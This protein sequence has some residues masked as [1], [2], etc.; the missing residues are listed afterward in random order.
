MLVIENV[1]IFDGTS[2]SEQKTIFI[3]NGVIQDV[4]SSHPLSFATKNKQENLKDIQRIRGDNSLLVPGFIDIQVNGAGGL[5]WNDSPDAETLEKIAVIHLKF[6]TTGILPTFISD[7]MEKM[8]LACESAHRVLQNQNPSI[9]GIHFE[10]PYLNQQKK[11]IHQQEFIR[12]ATSQEINFILDQ[13]FPILL[14]T[15]APEKFPENLLKSLVDANVHIFAGHSNASF[16]ESQ[17][18][19]SKGVK[20]V[21]HFFNA[22]SQM[23]SRA[24]GLVG[25]ALLHD[26]IWCGI[27]ADGKHV[28]FECLKV[29]FK[30]RGTDHFILVS[31]AMPGV[32]LNATE[33]LLQGQTIYIKNGGYFDA[34]GTLAGASLTILDALKNIVFEANVPLEK[35]ISMTS[36]NAAK[37]LGLSKKGAVA[38]GYD[39]DVVLLDKKTLNLIHVIQQGR[40]VK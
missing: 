4:I 24:P 21:T 14:L 16:E 11:G 27:I 6:G 13:K 12:E 9:I 23:T 20:G 38:P 36:T 3:E 19:F 5:L 17:R 32:G 33:F 10:G 34:H 15:I 25:A 7:S 2:I 35:A 18:A 1:D 30:C 29:A 40:L 39:A 28:S 22:C 8:Q 31:D 26:N 37:C